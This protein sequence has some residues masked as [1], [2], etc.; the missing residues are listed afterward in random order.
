RDSCR[1]KAIRIRT[2]WRRTG[3]HVRLA[4]DSVTPVLQGRFTGHGRRKRQL[5][6]LI[7]HTAYI[8]RATAGRHDHIAFTSL[9]LANAEP[10][11]GNFGTGLE[12]AG[13]ICLNEPGPTYRPNAELGGGVKYDLIVRYSQVG[14]VFNP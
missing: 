10:Q 11:P 1:R 7:K 13:T 14:S 6:R 3:R 2:D 4:D 12:C 9:A 5:V 8:G